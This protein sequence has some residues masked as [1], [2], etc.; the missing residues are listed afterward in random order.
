M[1]EAL[2]SRFNR[3]QSRALVVGVVGLTL[4]LLGAFVSSR[5]QFF[6]SYLFGYLFWLGLSLGC[7]GIAMLQ[8]LTGGRWGFVIRRI[9]EAG[10]TNIPLMALLFVPLLF[11]LPELYAWARPT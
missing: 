8:H 4:C 7:L 2:R 11:G 1:N 5:R 9:L 10:F 6:A 3:I